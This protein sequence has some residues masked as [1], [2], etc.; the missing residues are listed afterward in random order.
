M[1]LAPCEH[2]STGGQVA[3]FLAVWRGVCLARGETKRSGVRFWPVL[4]PPGRDSVPHDWGAGCAPFAGRVP[5]GVC[6]SAGGS[7]YHGGRD[8]VYE[9]NLELLGR[10]KGDGMEAIRTL[11]YVGARAVPT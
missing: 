9:W 4:C 2:G 6:V 3:L 7:M 10:D 8:C 11:Y 1:P 5:L